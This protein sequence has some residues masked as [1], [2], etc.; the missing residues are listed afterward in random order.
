MSNYTIV[1]GELY[2]VGVKGMKW[3]VRKEYKYARNIYR[4]GKK[5]HSK[6]DL[7]EHPGL[8]VKTQLKFDKKIAGDSPKNR[9]VSSGPFNPGAPKNRGVSSGPF[10]PGAPERKTKSKRPETKEKVAKAI[11]KGSE[12]AS[13]LL[14]ASLA[15]DIFLGGKGKKVVKEGVKQTGRAA[16]SAY[17]YA[18]GGRNIRW[19]DN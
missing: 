7:A 17:M 19:Y 6:G 9:G 3:G 13:K 11:K 1:N 14:V 5:V 15:D 12:I 10:N 18:R 16:V 2:H 4:K 8:G